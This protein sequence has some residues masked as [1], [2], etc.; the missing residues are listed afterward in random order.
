MFTQVIQKSCLAAIL[1][2][3]AACQDKPEVVEQIRS[4]KTFTVTELAT[5]Q[6]RRFPGI[7][8]ATD[9]S[10][11][12]FEVGGKVQQVTV[13]IGDHVKKGQLLASLDKEP[14]KLDVQAAEADLASARSDY[15][16]KKQQ[17]E[18]VDELE[19]KGWASKSMWDT[20][21]A[22]RDTARNQ[23]NFA[24][25]KLN[26]AKRNLRLT[27][28]TAPFDG[29]IAAR[30][31]EPHVKVLP[32]QKLFEIN[33]DGTMEVEFDISETII[34]QIHQGMPVSVTFP[35][36]RGETSAARISFIGSAA[37]VANSFPVK[38][39]LLDP[40][41]HIK[42]GM[43]ADIII[44][45]RDDNLAA[46]YLVPLAAIAPGN[47]SAFGYV[48][49]YNP[50][51]STVHKTPIEIPGRAGQNNM[52]QISKGVIAGD[53]IAVAGVSF[54]VDGQQVKLMQH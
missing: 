32:G 24:N 2:T 49:I 12:S 40:P 27:E 38:A 45:L 47:D 15:K 8:H 21:L 3:L 44:T 25:S 41:A 34:S 43:S 46:G 28:M 5:G 20:A 7:V 39:D 23:I 18:R 31:V 6:Q 1:I 30:M 54:L 9:S 16:N 4:L 17:F 29:S 37:G 36:L 14:Y 53:Q 19:K 10:S 42:P 51:T 50:D 22:A 11:L 13:D 33:A 52:V 48:F 35:T 26:L